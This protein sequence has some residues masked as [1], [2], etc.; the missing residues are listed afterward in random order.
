[1]T[2]TRRGRQTG[3]HGSAAPD[4]Q[5]R[6]R[7]ASVFADDPQG[8][9]CRPQLTLTDNPA[10]R[11]LHGLPAAAGS[12]PWIRISTEVVETYSN[13]AE[14]WIPANAQDRCR[15]SGGTD[16]AGAVPGLRRQA[17]PESEDQDRR[18]QADGGLRS[19]RLSRRSG[20]GGIHR[21]DARCGGRCSGSAESAVVR[22]DSGCAGCCAGRSGGV[23]AHRVRIWTR[24]DLHAVRVPDDPHH[25]VVFPEP[26]RRASCRRWCFRSGIVVLFCALGLGVTALAGPFGVAQLGGNPWV[27]AFI[28][29]VFWH[30]RAELAGRV[31]DYPALGPA[32]QAR[33]RF[34]ARRLLRH[35]A[36]GADVFADLVRLRGTLRGTAA[37]VVGAGARVRSRWSAWRA[38]ATG[39]A[40]PFFFL[41]AFPS[42]LKKLPKS[43]GW[44]ARV[45][46]VMGFVLLAV[47][48]KYLSNIDQV[49]QTNLLT[50]ERFL[51]AWFVL[52][53]MAGLYLL[54]LLRLEG[55]E[56]ED[57]LGIGRLLHRRSLPD[58]RRQ[59][60]AG[61]VRRAAGRAGCLRPRGHRRSQR[62]QHAPRADSNG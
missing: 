6:T 61:N 20:S 58:L 59:P 36:H 34:A 16:R 25:G 14:F 29:L 15:R 18:V 22:R 57:K 19:R 13:Q 27:N 32:D 7:L 33:Q 55:I 5:D 60:A 53:A 44:L 10:R 11:I 39:L 46:V 9:A 45:K 42:Y 21:S 35:A 12:E 40:S 49:L 48:L 2:S 26:A 37:G 24:G 41:A 30:L 62:K 50:R 38:F 31:R 47:M 3:R 52:F 8:S 51:A 23:R 28:A 17:V 56:A 4:R 43:G 1:M 54:G